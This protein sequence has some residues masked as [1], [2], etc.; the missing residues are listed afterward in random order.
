MT[1]D[2]MKEILNDWKRI[3]TGAQGYTI[4]KK[5]LNLGAKIP[6]IS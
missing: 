4:N 3:L 5:F 6:F 2:T 1:S